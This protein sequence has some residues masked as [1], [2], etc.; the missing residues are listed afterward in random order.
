MLKKTFCVLLALLLLPLAVHAEETS[1]DW[2]YRVRE[3][4][5]AVILRYTG[6]QADVTLNWN[7]NGHMIREIGAEAFA[8]NAAL[9]SVQLPVSVQIIR[10]NAFRGCPNLQNVVL[11]TLLETIEDGAFKECPALLL[12]TLP[13][14]LAEM[15]DCFDSTVTLTGSDQSMAASYAAAMG[16]SSAAQ[17]APT[18]KPA[19]ADYQ[20]TVQNGAAVITSYTGTDSTVV[21]PA[22]LGGYPVRTIGVSAFT[23]RYE[24]ETLILPE[25]LTDIEKTAFRHCDSLRSVTFPSTLRT[26][27][28]HA[29]NLCGNLEAIVLP[30]GFVS[31]GD[32][33]FQG[34]SNLRYITLPASLTSIRNYTFFECHEHLII[35]APAGS[36][37]EDFAFRKGYSFVNK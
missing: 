28:D 16:L 15:G 34:C 26:I 32:R 3:D 13:D 4:G 23:Y 5:G 1:G 21:V 24:M 31:L 7:L 36:A 33:A 11:P 18:E 17:A 6:S 25:G 9:R 20:Y 22:T 19:E 8:G 29:F 10:E 30:E 37:A 12:V 27:G 14:A 35:Y 2:V